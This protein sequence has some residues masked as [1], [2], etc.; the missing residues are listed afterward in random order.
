MDFKTYLGKVLLYDLLPEDSHSKCKNC[1]MTTIKKSVSDQDA[2]EEGVIN[3][4]TQAEV[5]PP[6]LE[7]KIKFKKGLEGRR[8]R[9]L[10]FSFQ[11]I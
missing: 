2:L 3:L 5:L 7:N 10:P 11:I 6:E 9:Y 1:G 4:G 8:R